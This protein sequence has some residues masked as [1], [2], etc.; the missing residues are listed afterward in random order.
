[1]FFIDKIDKKRQLAD[2]PILLEIDKI[3]YKVIDNDYNFSITFYFN[4]NINDIAIFFNS[5]NG[6]FTITK[7]QFKNEG[8]NGIITYNN[9]EERKL[10]LYNISIINEDSSIF[11]TDFT[12]LLYQNELIIN[13]NITFAL[14]KPNSL[15][16]LINLKNEI[17]K[18]QI[19]EI[20][21]I[22]DKVENKVEKSNYL[23]NNKELQF[24]I[25]LNN[26]DTP[27]NYLFTIYDYTNKSHI[28]T[29]IVTN[30]IILDP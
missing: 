12:F 10:G 18:E 14:I 4:E 19:K 21:Y 9:N 15:D 5:K 6:N 7:E 30:F 28:F 13:L 24:N 29:L 1:M 3:S 26:N 2:N 11:E 8:N 20:N 17:F 25:P 16:F 22:K 27:A 23:I